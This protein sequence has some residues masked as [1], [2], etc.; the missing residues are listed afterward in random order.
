MSTREKAKAQI[1]QVAGK[2][3]RKAAHAVGKETIAAKGAA[4]EARGKARNVKEKR[5]GTFR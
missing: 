4:L 5:K 1:E 2:A 3:V